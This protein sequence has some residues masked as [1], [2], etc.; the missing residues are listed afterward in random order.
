MPYPKV[1]SLHPEK[2]QA[3]LNVYSCAGATWEGCLDAS[4]LLGTGIGRPGRWEEKRPRLHRVEKMDVE[5]H[6]GRVSF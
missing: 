3:C 4:E 1:K 5:D 2:G 6:G